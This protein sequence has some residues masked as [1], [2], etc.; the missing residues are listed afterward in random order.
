MKTHKEQSRTIKPTIGDDSQLDVEFKD[1]KLIH[2]SIINSNDECQLNASNTEY[3]D[4]LGRS[5]LNNEFDIN[6]LNG[7][8][9][10]TAK[11]LSL[12]DEIKI[13]IRKLW[14]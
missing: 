12:A 14:N 1:G 2:M 7:E 13:L 9:Q 8:L 3:R 4:E 11:K 10:L 6:F 5:D